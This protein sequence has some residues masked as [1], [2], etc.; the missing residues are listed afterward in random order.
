LGE[1]VGQY[2]LKGVLGGGGM[3][4]VYRGEH[5]SGI[6]MTAAIKKLHP[7]LAADAELR[8]R[9]KVEAQ[10]LARLK[11][12]NIV[13]LFDYV[14]VD[15]NCALITEL[16]EGRTMRAVMGEFINLPMP[17]SLALRL[18]RQVLEGVG[19][20]H[21]HSC[22]HRDLKPANIMVTA[23]NEVKV[24]DFGIANLVDT[25]RLT[26]TGVSIG[27][28][29]YMSPEQ[30]EGRADLDQ[31]ADLYALGM[32]FWEMLFGPG[33]RPIGERGWR[34]SEAHLE[35]LLDRQV[36]AS[37]VDVVRLMVQHDREDRY[38][39]CDE[40]LAALGRIV[41]EGCLD[42]ESQLVLSGVGPMGSPGD[43]PTFEFEAT[44]KS[45]DSLPTSQT[46]GNEAQEASGEPASRTPVMVAAAVLAIGIF[47]VVAW[48]GRSPDA[49]QAPAP[50]A[51]QAPAP[52]EGVALQTVALQLAS[53]PLGA[54]LRLD[55]EEL[56]NDS[57]TRLVRAEPKGYLLTAELSGYQAG[58]MLCMVDEQAIQQGYFRCTVP[59]QKIQ[60][61]VAPKPSKSSR[62]SERRSGTRKS[63]RQPP[64]PPAEKAKPVEP[65]PEKPKIHKIDD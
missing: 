50:D 25:E 23:D 12:P 42:E 15:G 14:D 4:T 49:V 57:L 29:V 41:E 2:E 21:R 65:P 61:E 19:H 26:R 63:T 47:A 17:L 38:N 22:L 40:V 34:L 46:V 11:H 28:P 43:L 31:R 35:K 48:S 52:D 36:P 45:S 33:A 6:G 37:L 3:A 7:H 16:V 39:S 9:L 58:S 62:R 53:D 59:L 18:F 44:A 56:G 64:A 1:Q 27:T 5:V 30:L 55:G 13:Q 8:A 51:V 10:A 32:T 60:T 20:A 54:S 24:L